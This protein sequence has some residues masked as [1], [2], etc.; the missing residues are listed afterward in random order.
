MTT[1]TTQTRRVTTGAALELTRN[2]DWRDDSAC[3][4]EP[5]EMFFPIGTTGRAL[6]QTLHA[7]AV[8]RRCPVREECLE[9]ALR[10][11]QYTGVWGGLSEQERRGLHDDSG[12]AFLRCLEDQEYIEARREDGVGVRELAR[13]LGVSYEMVRRALRYFEQE[14]QQ[15]EASAEEVAAA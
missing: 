14:R 4:Q 7:K 3:R 15:S 12:T 13:E 6:V 10:N 11:G 9:W 8:C 5:P 1:T 2:Y